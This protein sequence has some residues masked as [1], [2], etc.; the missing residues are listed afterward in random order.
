V[1]FIAGLDDVGL[2]L[3]PAALPGGCP[4]EIAPDL[5][6][7]E[8]TPNSGRAWRSIPIPPLPSLVD[9]IVHTQWA[10]YDPMGISTSNTFA[11]W[12]GL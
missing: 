7:L 12:I 6:Q 3:L 4:L 2:G 10:H 8:I 5:V 11:N 1:L 9:T